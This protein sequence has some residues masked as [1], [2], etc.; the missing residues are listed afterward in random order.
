MIALV[1]L[2]LV[3]YA[4]HLCQSVVHQS[5]QKRYLHNDAVVGKALHKR[6]GHSFGHLI[7]IIVIRLVTH[8]KHRLLN[9][10]N[11]VTEQ[12]HRYHGDTIAIGAAIL[13]NVVRIG[14]LGA[15]ILAETQCLRFQPCFLQLNE[16]KFQSAVLLSHLCSKV[17]AEH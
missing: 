12:I 8:I 13:V 7:A 1:F 3:K 5:V 16:H 17:N 10:S 2:F 9:F 14:I 4:Q 6:V 15:E 11:T